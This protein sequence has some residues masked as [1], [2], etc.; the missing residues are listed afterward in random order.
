MRKLQIDDTGAIRIAIQQEIGRSEES[1][2]DHRLHGLLLLAAGH[3][4]QDVAALF[5]EDDTTV[6]RWFHR[7]EEGGLQALRESERPGRPRSLDPEQWRE[8]QADLRKS[9]LDLGLTA[10]TWD[11]SS[12]SAHLRR[13][14]GVQLG[15][16]QCQRIFRQMGFRTRG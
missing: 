14:F 8:L 9:P 4:C 1:R 2:Y 10:A 5:G 6:Q 12:L 15:V 7:F 3:S 16:R 13:R 11:G